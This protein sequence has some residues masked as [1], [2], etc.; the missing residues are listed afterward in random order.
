MPP[1]DDQVHEAV[2]SAVRY[3][4][5]RHTEN[6]VVYVQ[7]E[8]Q[9]RIYADGKVIRESAGAIPGAMLAQSEEISQGQAQSVIELGGAKAERSQAERAE[10]ELAKRKDEE[11][12][13]LKTALR[14]T[15]GLVPAIGVSVGAFFA[16]RLSPT[17]HGSN[18]LCLA[19]G[20]GLAAA[21]V[22]SLVW[23]PRLLK[24]IRYSLILW[25]VAWLVTLLLWVV[26]VAFMYLSSPNPG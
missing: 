11:S 4:T 17:S 6:P 23:N 21:L 5:S 18:F 26:I 19:I 14:F 8:G 3:Y 2:A 15:A 24:N 9:W 7:E 13:L 20:V 12:E 22:S 1:N 10:T 16:F 25:A